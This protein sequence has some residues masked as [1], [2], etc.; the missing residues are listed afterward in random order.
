MN[1]QQEAQAK[2][3]RLCKAYRAVF[4]TEGHRNDAQQI[5]WEDMMERWRINR[6]VFIPNTHVSYDGNEAVNMATY[7]PIKAAITDGARLPIIQI[8]EFIE[9]NFDEKTKPE[10]K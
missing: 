8:K 4:G 1:L 5:V 6:P 2:T 7:D 9:R 10:I 3:K